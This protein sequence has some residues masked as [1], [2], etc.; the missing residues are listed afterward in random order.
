MIQYNSFEISDPGLSSYRGSGHRDGESK[1]NSETTL[2]PTYG[3]YLPTRSE[4]LALV[5]A[6]ASTAQKKG[7]KRVDQRHGIQKESIGFG[8][9][10]AQ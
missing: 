6:V 7:T 3:E 5:L 10:D 8:D 4:N 9:S 1:T 2:M